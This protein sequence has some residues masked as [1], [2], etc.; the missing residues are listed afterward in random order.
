MQLQRNIL[1]N[2]Q[3]LLLACALQQSCNCLISEALLVADHVSVRCCFSSWRPSHWFLINMFLHVGFSRCLHALVWFSCIIMKVNGAYCCDVLLLKQLLPDICQVAGDF[4]FPVHHACARALSCCDTRLRTSHQT[5]H[6]N[7][8]DLSSVDYRLL[9]H[10][11][12]HLSE[13]AVD[14]EHRWWAVVINRMIF[15]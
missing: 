13:T 8:P 2:V 15:Y 14:I 1:A 9:S 10:S 12:M 11:G 3:C 7:R 4:C 6:P 5:W